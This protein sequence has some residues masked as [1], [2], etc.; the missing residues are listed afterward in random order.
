[1]NKSRKSSRSTSDPSR[2]TNVLDFLNL[3][4]KDY[5]AARVLLNKGLCLQ[6]AILGSTA[7][8]KHFKAVLA[9]RGEKASGH[10]QTA[11]FNSVRNFVPG[12]YSKLSTSF[13]QF[14]QQCYKLRYLDQLPENFN[15]N[16][17]A[18][19]TLAELDFTVDT[20]Q[21]EVILHD[22][23]G[24][25]INIPYRHA[26]LHPTSPSH[27]HILENNYLVEG[28]EKAVFLKRSEVWFA[29]RQRPGKG[30]LEADFTT[31]ESRNDGDFLRPAL[32]PVAPMAE[33]TGT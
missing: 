33:Q 8:E 2:T 18:R 22:Q 9:I 13:L 3:G 17:G 29:I 20:I 6:G 5:V 15:L 4:L 12:M 16:I 24:V 14:L 7:V 27:R 23:N 30:I 1:M 28:V 32:V 11:H 19:M 21:A 25:E 26:V 10:L 31:F